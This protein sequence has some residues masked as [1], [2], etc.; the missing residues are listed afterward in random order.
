MKSIYVIS[1]GGRTAT[2]GICRM[3][4]YFCEEWSAAGRD[5]PLVVVDSSGPYV[6]WKMP[7]YFAWS[8]V[9]ILAAAL[10]R[11]IALLHIHTAANGSI[12]RKSVHISIGKMFRIPVV[13]HMHAADFVPFYSGLPEF[14]RRMVTYFMRKADRF[15]VLGDSWRRYYIDTVGLD[16]RRVAVLRNAVPGPASLAPKP[17]AAGPCRMIFLGI[18]SNRKGLNELIRA[19]ADP[20]VA[21]LSWTLDVAGNGDQAPFANLAEQLGISSKVRFR[22][23][24]ESSVAR[25]LL[26][27]SDILLLPS[28]HEGLPMVILEA[29]AYGVA[30]IATR[31]G[32][33][34]EAVTNNAT[35]I[36]V[37]P[38]N[39]PELAEALRRLISD[40]ELRASMGTA[41]RERY[42]REFHI[43]RL[44]ERLE[45]MFAELCDKGPPEAP[46]RETTSEGLI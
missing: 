23:W 18:L 34:D 36:L 40:R 1:P 8:V 31:V 15:I 42:L 12:V 38:G 5:P 4:D 39:V 41:G 21:G 32:S 7:F 26:S 17:A 2:G 35:G 19:L 24:M 46:T 27:Q 22:G 11:D 28:H 37:E 13:V 33:V 20:S 25:G 43:G 3:V 9:V 29:M 6:A 30:V 10:R 16:P 45:T 44:N 14:G